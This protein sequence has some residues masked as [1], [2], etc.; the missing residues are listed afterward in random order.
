MIN[1]NPYDLFNEFVFLDSAVLKGE[2]PNKIFLEL[3]DMIEQTNR[4]KEHPLA[5][6]KMHRNIGK[7]SYQISINTNLLND[8]FTLPYI[9]YLGEYYIHKLL[10]KPIDSLYRGLRLREN[11]GHFDGYDM[12]I[13]YGY[14]GDI[15]PMHNHAG[16]LSGNIYIKNDYQVPT[17]FISG[18]EHKG[19]PGD[20]IIFP[21]DLKHEVEEL[22]EDQE[23]ITIA[24]N[25]DGFYS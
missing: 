19:V 15:N 22:K 13:N 9:N 3:L 20:I 1:K 14:K 2:L 23:R 16:T 12:W 21:S 24:F 17:R 18:V 8:S 10:N 25:L 6:L 4:I 7:N 5:Y 11:R